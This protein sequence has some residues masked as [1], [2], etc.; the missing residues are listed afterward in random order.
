M[1]RL[2]NLL[3][4]SADYP[5]P[6]QPAK[7]RAIFNLLSASTGQAAHHVYSLNR[8]GWRNGVAAIEF[9]DHAGTAHRAVAYGAPPRGLMMATRLERLAEWIAEDV[10][11]RGLRPDAIHAHKISVEGLVGLRLSELLCAPLIISSQGDSDLKI[12]GFKRGLRDAYRRIWRESALA[13]PFA[14]W[15][16][17]RLTALLGP[18]DKPTA[19]LPC[20][21]AAEE[22]LLA[23][24]IVG[25][26]F[27]SAFHLGV[28]GRKNA[29]GLIRAI[30]M[31]ARTV[32]G[33]RLEI[34]GGGDPAAFRRLSAEAERAAP[35]RIRFVGALPHAEVGAFFNGACAF[36]MPSRRESFG[37]VFV[38][39]LF[40]G[41]P[42]LIPRG[43]G[44]DGYLPDGG[45]VLASDS[46]PEA[47]ADGLVRL[48]HEEGVFKGNLELLAASGGL[49]IFRRTTVAR[50]YEAAL[51][52]TISAI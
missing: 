4:L 29:V 5:D 18:R 11:R 50:T 47:V 26:L 32:P 6:L 27:R 33:I 49:E 28:A 22:T 37:M 23:P 17:D 38:E 39:A 13:F 12:I 43:W 52:K 46:S 10:A 25:P 9:A 2:M 35:G 31:A 21:A 8:A 40:A 36:A 20:P 1:N 3:H 24:R 19:L 44:I 42:C 7:T 30:G 15:T 45:A 48:T 16:Q 34:A 41:A 51:R 14:P